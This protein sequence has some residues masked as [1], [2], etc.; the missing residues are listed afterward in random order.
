M[1]YFIT[2][3]VLLI[4]IVGFSQDGAKPVEVTVEIQKKDKAG[5]K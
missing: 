2:T 4:Q 3:V 1:K 5:H